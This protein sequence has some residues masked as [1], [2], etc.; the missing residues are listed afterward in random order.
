MYIKYYYDT[1]CYKYSKSLDMFYVGL[2]LVKTLIN[3]KCSQRYDFFTY[4]QALFYQEI[5]A[6]NPRRKMFLKSISCRR[7]FDSLYCRLFSSTSVLESLHLVDPGSNLLETKNVFDTYSN[8][9]D[10][11]LNLLGT[12]S[13]LFNTMFDIL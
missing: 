7:N 8:L 3:K 13:N 12:C 6:Q 5:H 9:L 11:C 1:Q 4:D 10:P 2:V